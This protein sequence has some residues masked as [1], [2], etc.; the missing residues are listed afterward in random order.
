MLPE[1]G[2]FGLEKDIPNPLDPV[3]YISDISFPIGSL[4]CSHLVMMITM[5]FRGYSMAHDLVTPLHQL[6][7][8]LC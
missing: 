6:V 8:Q 4:V 2:S 3:L 1:M 5:W 7:S